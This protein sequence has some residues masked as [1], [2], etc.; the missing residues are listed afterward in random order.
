MRLVWNSFLTPLSSD[1]AKEPFQPLFFCFHRRA[2]GTAVKMINGT[3]TLHFKKLDVLNHIRNRKALK[4]P[5]NKRGPL[6]IK[7]EEMQI[8]GTACRLED[9]TVMSAQTDP[10]RIDSP[11]AHKSG[12]WLAEQVK[13]FVPS[14]ETIHLRGLHYAMVASADVLLPDGKNPYINDKNCWMF[15]SKDA[16]EASRWLGYLPFERIHDGRHEAPEFFIP[17]LV[18][19]ETQFYSS[20]SVHLDAT[21]SLSEPMFHCKPNGS[22]E[23]LVQQPYRICLIGEKSS[24][25]KILLPVARSVGGELLLPTGD[26]SNT[27]IS[28]IERRAHAD[29]RPLVVL[30]FSDFD[31]SGYNMPICV[32]RKLQALIDLRG[33]HELEVQVH[34]VALT[35]EQ[36][37]EFELPSSPL[38]EKEKRAGAWKDAWDHEQTEID[39]LA[40]LRPDILQ[41]IAEDA[42]K[43]FFDATLSERVDSAL[44]DWKERAEEVLESDEKYQEALVKAQEALCFLQKA[45]D[46]LRKA[47]RGTFQQIDWID[48]PELELPE[49]EISHE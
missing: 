39:A 41:Q 32:A 12:Q 6:A 8:K 19:P 10:Y 23:T 22:Y 2:Y 13:R 43:P 1:R 18:E 36:V 7:L 38:K 21:P 44:S 49:P 37:R 14:D 35:H 11:D 15:M 4:M 40:T 3:T 31:P 29:G 17:A 34:D 9:L 45:S 24:L 20:L 25:K 27:M 48:V 42:V 30:Y 46:E 26:I 47:N 5:S 16:A 28:G 33:H